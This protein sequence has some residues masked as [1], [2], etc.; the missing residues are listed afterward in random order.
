MNIKYPVLF[1]FLIVTL[2]AREKL[3]R[4]NEPV[5]NS[6][7]DPK[8]TQQ[9]LYFDQLLDHY[10]YVDTVTWKQRYFAVEDYFN[11]QNG[12]VILYICGE[13]TCPGVPDARKW[14]VQIAEKTQGLI[15]VLE[16]R[17]YGKSL[18]FGNDSLSLENLKFL[19]TEQAL[20]DLAYFIDQ[21]KNNHKH[22]I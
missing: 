15:L 6:S 17:Y 5:V 8:Y 13:Y 9:E 10:N 21:N 19:N 20:K 22:K 2:L 12:P 14:A 3:H 16:H 4:L 7:Y 11:P 18:P 1:C